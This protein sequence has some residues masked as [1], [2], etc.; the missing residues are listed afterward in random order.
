MKKVISVALSLGLL[1]GAYAMP[2]DAKKKKRKPKR[3]ER[4]VEL[5]Y[6]APGIG[7]TAAG[8]GGGL[9]PFADPAAQQ[10]I[11]IMLEPGETYIKVELTDATG[12]PPMGY[13]SQ[14]DTD[15]DGIGN[16]Y[17]DFC[18]GH[19]EPIPM[20]STA[21]VRI[22]FYNGVDPACAPNA[23]TTGDIKVTLSNMP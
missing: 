21:P 23:A 9:C 5:T 14:G 10:C 4:V 13:I 15:G 8:V 12:L 16:L 11:E 19:T 6:S 2:A 1:A 20:E 3:I 7:A 22:S 18:G 17:G